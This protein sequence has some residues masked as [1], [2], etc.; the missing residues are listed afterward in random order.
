MAT[1]VNT[2]SKSAAVRRQKTRVQ[3]A[4]AQYKIAI[5]YIACAALVLLSIVFMAAYSA[6][7][8]QKNNTLT[9]E[10]EM[11]Q[12]EIDSLK[13]QINNATSIE[14]VEKIA[15]EKYGMTQQSSKNYVTIKDNSSKTKSLA[16]VIKKEAYN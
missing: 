11:L 13:E 16:D 6:N 3:A 10:N 14:K 12:A 1:A 5:K 9:S 8:Q 15:T 2:R 4:S 7:L